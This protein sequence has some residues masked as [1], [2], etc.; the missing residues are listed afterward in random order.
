M[1]LKVVR[2]GILFGI[3]QQHYTFPISIFL[4]LVHCLVQPIFHSISYHVDD[5]LLQTKYPKVK[6]TLLNL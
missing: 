5:L 1:K 3:I 6:Y 4:P 2:L